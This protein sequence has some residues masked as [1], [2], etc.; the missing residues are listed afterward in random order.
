[1]AVA[2]HGKNLEKIDLGWC[3]DLTDRGN[4]QYHEMQAFQ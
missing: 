2:A 4:V 3:K 1:M